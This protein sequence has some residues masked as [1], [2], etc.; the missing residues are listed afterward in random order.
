MKGQIFCIKAGNGII[1]GEDR[2]WVREVHLEGTLP[3]ETG[4]KIH[5]AT[6]AP[7]H[8]DDEQIPGKVDSALSRNAARTKAAEPLEDDIPF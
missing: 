8:K 3:T 1:E 5:V 7:T 4:K 2:T 6:H